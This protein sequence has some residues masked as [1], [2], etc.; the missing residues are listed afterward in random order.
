MTTT[1]EEPY[2]LFSSLQYCS[3]L[4]Y[5]EGN[6]KICGQPCPFYMFPYHR[7]R[8]VQAAK[9]FGWT[10]AIA[11][12]Q[13]LPAVQAVCEKAVNELIL[14]NTEKD[15]DLEEKYPNGIAVRLRILVSK[16]GDVTA[17]P[18]LI[19]FIPPTR[20]FPT[21]LD[22]ETVLQTDLDLKVFSV[23]LDTRATTPTDYTRYKTTLR[24]HYDD[25][26]ERVG[27][28]SFTDPKEVILWS[29]NGLLMEGSISNVYFYRPEKGGWVT[30]TTPPDGD[31]TSAGGTAG[32]VRRWLLEKGF[33]TVADVKK[34]D[35]KLG[36]WVW[37]SNGVKGMFLGKIASLGGEVDN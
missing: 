24:N 27:I 2:Q 37:M 11:A 1:A 17:E 28:A 6:T 4:E 15:V 36:E 23:Y 30:P 29:P 31:S 25:A 8:I 14:G 5:E 16:S 13:D 7:D 26:R 22:P 20:L 21:T 33:V 19:P 10:E 3:V 9:N 35:V 34:D 12:L 18:H 32:T